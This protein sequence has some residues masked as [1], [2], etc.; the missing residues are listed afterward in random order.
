MDPDDLSP[1]THSDPL[2]A[3]ARQDIDPLSV[4]ELQA[5]IVALEDEIARCRGRLAFAGKHRTLAEGLF[6]R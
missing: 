2:A 5:R 4:D 6:K 3:L 1:R